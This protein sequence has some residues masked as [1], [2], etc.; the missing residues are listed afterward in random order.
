MSVLYPDTRPEAEQVQIALLRR[1]PAWRKLE[2]L[3]QL[4]ETVRTLAGPAVTAAV[5]ASRG[6]PPGVSIAR[7][8]LDRA[9]SGGGRTFLPGHG[10]VWL[11]NHGTQRHL[12]WVRRTATQL[13]HDLLW[14][15]VDGAELLSE[16]RTISCRPAASDR[17]WI[18]VTDFRLTNVSGRDVEIR[19]PAS[20][21]RVGAGYGGY[22][23][24]APTGPGGTRVFTADAD[25]IGAVHGARAPWLAV[26]GSDQG[27]RPWTLVFVGGTKQTSEDPWFVR[28]RDYI[29]VG[30]A[31]SWERPLMIAPRETLHRRVA[32]VVAD[33]TLPP[34]QAAP[35]AAEAGAVEAGA[36]E[37]GS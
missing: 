15:T 1:A 21:G 37:A 8:G 14:T 22:F 24:R 27:D 12:R 35:L 7:L 11:D 19:S 31:L 23:W 4:N 5:P 17:A 26:T 25:G 33:G 6:H 28:I 13:Q 36:V 10:P 2:M 32:V 9:N 30:S 3:G 18:L 20:H 29:G 16:R 34:D